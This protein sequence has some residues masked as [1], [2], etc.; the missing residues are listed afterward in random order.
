M[1][2]Y[3]LLSPEDVIVQ[4]LIYLEP[5]DLFHIA[6][7]YPLRLFNTKRFWIDKFNFD[8]AEIEWG[9]FT[10]IKCNNFTELYLN[11]VKF[12][13]V[14]LTKK[15]RLDDLMVDQKSIHFMN[16]KVGQTINLFTI[17]NK[18]KIP[19]QLENILT[20]LN[21]NFSTEQGIEFYITYNNKQFY[22]DLK[23]LD[24]KYTIKIT[25]KYALEIF[26][27]S[28]TLMYLFYVIF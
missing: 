24:K 7:M 13:N 10:E 18:V 27:Y 2:N 8:F 21:I 25:Y 17:G 26:M 15:N 20:I 9:L 12:R 3:F 4:I 28:Q 6:E 19:D 14:Y 16:V 22:V 1:T 5:F 23:I 11:Y